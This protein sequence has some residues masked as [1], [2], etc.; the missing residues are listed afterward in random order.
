MKV[1]RNLTEGNI[2]RN[3]LLYALPLILSAIL[4][5]LYSTVDAMIAGKFISEHALGAISAT[6]SFHSIS[7]SFMLGFGSGFSVYAAQLFGKRDNGALKRDILNVLTFVSAFSAVLSII[8]IAFFEPVLDYLNVDPILRSDAKI[9]FIIYTCGYI[10]N[11]T[12]MTLMYT[13]Y[14]LGVTGFTVYL[15]VASA[16]INIGGNLLS[17]LVF[18]LGVAGLA[19]STVLSIAVSTVVYVYMMIKAF[20]ELRSEK[21]KYRFSF[22]SVKRSL[23]FTIPTALQQLS[24]HGVAILI[25]PAINA[26]GAAATTGYTVSNKMFGLC[27]LTIWQI[28][29][30]VSCYTAQCV[31]EEKYDKIPRGMRA[32]FILN[33]A[34]LLPLVLTFVIFAKPIASLYFPAGFVGEAFEYAVRF[35]THYMPFLFVIMI[36]HTIH[37]YLRSLGCVN[38]VFWVTIWTS[39]ILV[40]ATLILIPPLHMEG[41]FMGKIAS[42]IGDTLVSLVLY[43]L[44]FRSAEQIK[45]TAEKYGAKK[46][47]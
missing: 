33:S 10:L 45:K 14:A 46:K 25:S 42:W 40:A 35:S 30:A 41:V 22:S 36:G 29:S 17:V 6:D 32:G 28:T 24:Y 12:N 26:L 3:F 18:D 9:Y 23:R 37:A 5:N 27:S 4:G 21:I 31:G 1:T 15:S 34:L 7:H 19:I 16:L 11:Y 38:I 44:F 39:T 47:I 8:S 43:L 20:K 13:L 2:Y